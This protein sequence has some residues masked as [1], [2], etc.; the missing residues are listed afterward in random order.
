MWVALV[1]FPGVELAA[2]PKMGETPQKPRFGLSGGMGVSYI[3]AGD[4]VDLVNARSVTSR[5]SDFKAAVEFFAA[6]GVPISMNWIIK[7]EYGYV[8]GTYNTTD[9]FGQPTEITFF[10]HLPSVIGQYVLV[11]EGLYN[12][13]VGVGAG[14]HFGTYSERLYDDFM[15]R[16]PG[17]VADLEANTAFGEDFYAY[18]GGNLRWEF[19]GELKNR[20]G[21]P[22]I[23]GNPVPTMNFFGI[24]ARLGFT[25]YF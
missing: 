8:L 9:P 10:A 24:G 16:G 17:A 2:Q 6:V 21:S 15:G 23:A 5:V 4:I 13:K 19:I 14:Y 18:L 3:N 25:Y 22:I 1:M 7:F 11:D 12:V 20:A